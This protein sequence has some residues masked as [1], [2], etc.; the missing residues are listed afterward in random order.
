M[1]WL[2]TKIENNE[3]YVCHVNSLN[4]ANIQN[5]IKYINFGKKSGNGKVY[6]IY[7][8]NMRLLKTYFWSQF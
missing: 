2:D 1:L 3:T 6:R 7:S 8:R 5:Y 4:Q